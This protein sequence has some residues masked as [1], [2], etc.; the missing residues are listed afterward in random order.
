[1]TEKKLCRD[2][3]VIEDRNVIGVTIAGAELRQYHMHLVHTK[4]KNEREKEDS[5][6]LL[7]H[8]DLSIN[9]LFLNT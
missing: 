5:G 8:R 9:V 2:D 1:M 6:K 4:R 3:D 7:V